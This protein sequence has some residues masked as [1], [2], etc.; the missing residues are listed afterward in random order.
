MAGLGLEGAYGAAKFGDTLHKLLQEREAA[1]LVAEA[2]QAKA[3]QQ[4]IENQ[5]RDR[6]LS[7]Q[8][9]Q[10][11]EQ[12]AERKATK[13]ATEGQQESS[14]L[15][16]TI[17]NTPGHGDLTGAV[18][19]LLQSPH[20]QTQ[21]L[22]RGLTKINSPD[23][24]P[25]RGLPMGLPEGAAGA[26]FQN[27]KAPAVSPVEPTETLHSVATAKGPVMRTVD[28]V[29]RKQIGE[30]V[31]EYVNPQSGRGADDRSYQYTR[32]R[33]DTLKMPIAARADRLTRLNDALTAESPAIDPLIAPELIS[34]MAGGQGTGIRVTQ[35]EIQAAVGGRNKW[36]D[37]QA[38]V[39]R[40]RMDPSKPFLVTPEQRKQIQAIVTLT[41]GRVKGAL[42]DIDAAGDE[43]VD[44][45]DANS[46]RAIYN[47]L[48]KKLSVHAEGGPAQ[49]AVDKPHATGP[50]P[51]TDKT[52]IW[53]SPTGPAHFVDG[54]GW[55]SG[56]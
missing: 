28:R 16:A 43:L 8:E 56:G 48:Q 53:D 33:I 29:T 7:T 18:T 19:P 3:T 39:D 54:Q 2:T 12:E 32:S 51:P 10:L 5:Q 26:K 30:D 21:T 20:Q 37:L 49:T 25:M 22:I 27:P 36:Q 44:A 14:A 13:F 24:A 35:G 17:D 11:A 41:A 38:A 52:M 55:V 15:G 46:H 31:P 50:K 6:Q 23:V 45:P 4:G 42:D 40:W 9:R 1:R 34:S 47:K